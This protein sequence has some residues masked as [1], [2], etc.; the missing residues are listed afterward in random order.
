MI[1]LDLAA[2]VTTGRAMPGLL[3]EGPASGERGNRRA[4]S[5]AGVVYF[6]VEDD[7]GDTVRPRLLAAG[8]DPARFLVVTHVSTPAPVA[9]DDP[10]PRLA[11]LRDLAAIVRAI[12]RV[13]ARL[14]IFDPFNAYI[15]AETNAYRDTDVRRLLA[16]L[17]RIAHVT[18]A[19]FLFIRHRNKA[20][21]TPALYRG[22]GSIGIIGA[23]R[24][25]LVAGRDPSSP[26]GESRG[27]LASAKNNLSAQVPSLG[28]QIVADAE[29]LPVVRWLGESSLT[30]EALLAHPSREGQQ[31]A[32]KLEQARRWLE[33]T[34]AQGPRPEEELRLEAED[35]GFSYA[36]LRRAKKMLGAT[37]RPEGF[38]GRQLWLLP[39]EPPEAFEAI[40]DAE[41]SREAG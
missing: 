13:E 32:S 22:G 28:Y 37:S 21:G 11:T 2:R 7:P 18:Q 35:E 5:A 33:Q 31:D 26:P 23:A 36:T 25:G 38:Q 30:A 24:S 29:G 20:I 16:P 19:A 15:D 40:E 8:G 27:A 6:T 9:G 4:N 10:E 17:A 12:Q 41:P 1:A 39:P 14:V 34:L 3:P